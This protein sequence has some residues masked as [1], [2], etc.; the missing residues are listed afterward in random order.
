MKHELHAEGLVAVG[1]APQSRWDRDDGG[2]IE[3]SLAQTRAL[4][5]QEGY[6]VRCSSHCE[7]A[8]VGSRIAI[9]SCGCGRSVRNEA[10]PDLFWVWFCFERNKVSQ[11]PVNECTHVEVAALKP[12]LVAWSSQE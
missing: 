4:G 5:R 11:P 3:L 7:L 8:R 9:P 12:S 2:R 1:R 10:E 6:V